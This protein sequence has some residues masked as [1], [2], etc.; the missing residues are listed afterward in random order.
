MRPRPAILFR[1]SESIDAKAGRAPSA[2]VPPTSCL[3]SPGRT[4]LT[5]DPAEVSTVARERGQ[6]GLSDQSA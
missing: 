3:Q 5:E 4:F 1:A 2:G 6:M